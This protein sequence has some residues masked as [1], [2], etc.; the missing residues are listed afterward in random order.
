MLRSSF[1]EASVLMKHC[2]E[3]Q[4]I[5]WATVTETGARIT[6]PRSSV[7]LTVPQGAVRPGSSADLYVAVLQPEFF[8]PRLDDSQTAMTPVVRCGNLPKKSDFS[9][10]PDLLKPGNLREILGM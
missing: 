10:A 3:A 7:S 9:S 5:N 4:S 1:G 6:V 2:L 8:R